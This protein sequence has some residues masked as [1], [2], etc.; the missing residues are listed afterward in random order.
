LVRGLTDGEGERL[1]QE[2][3]L[4]APSLLN[5]DVVGIAHLQPIKTTKLLQTV[6]RNL[7]A[8]SDDPTVTLRGL[9]YRTAS[10][11]ECFGYLPK[12]PKGPG[13]KNM[14]VYSTPS[15][16]TNSPSFTAGIYRRPVAASSAASPKASWPLTSTTVGF[17]T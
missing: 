11:S 1:K 13:G 16:F 14:K 3:V 17:C 12:G 5:N 7:L 6:G 15:C 8:D 2:R 4:L 10:S 9:E